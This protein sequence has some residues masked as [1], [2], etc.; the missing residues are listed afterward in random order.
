MLQSIVNLEGNPSYFAGIRRLITGGKSFFDIQN[1][2][3]VK[4]LWK[5]MDYP[6]YS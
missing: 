1:K 2:C 4:K 3:L 6:F 5:L